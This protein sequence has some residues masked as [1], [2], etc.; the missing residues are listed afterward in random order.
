MASWRKRSIIAFTC[1]GTST[2]WKCPAP[3]VTPTSRSGLSRQHR[4]CVRPEL[5]AEQQ[6]RNLAARE[7]I[8]PVRTH[9]VAPNDRRS[10]RLRDGA[11]EVDDPARQLVGPCAHVMDD[12]R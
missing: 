8:V 3:T 11:H 2:W 7:G 9:P 6:H 4:V 1:W 12:F 5:R 10:D